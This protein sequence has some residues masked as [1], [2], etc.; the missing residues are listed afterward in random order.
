MTQK[1][2]LSE[3][4]RLFGKLESAADNLRRK[5][6]QAA[7]AELAYR[8]DVAQ[9]YMKARS[10]EELK[11]AADRDAWVNELVAET[12]MDKDIAEGM[13]QAALEEIRNLRQQLSFVQSAMRA[14]REEYDGYMSGQE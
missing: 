5:T 7:E 10:N 4:M 2:P 6:Q 13:R 1:T 14:D 8:R 11:Y 9:A 12:K 3:G